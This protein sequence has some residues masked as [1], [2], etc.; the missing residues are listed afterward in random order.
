MSVAVVICLG[1]V[2]G[3]I[4]LS[5]YRYRASPSFTKDTTWQLTTSPLVL[6]IFLQHLLQCSLSLGCRSF[7]VGVS[8]V[9]AHHAVVF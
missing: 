4:M 8:N 9:A 5:S 6:T 7:V 3:T 2:E 1:L